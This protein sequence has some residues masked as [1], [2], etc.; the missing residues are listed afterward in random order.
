MEPLTIA[1]L[2]ALTPEDIEVEFFDDRMELIDYETSTD[3][4]AITVETYTA[5]RAYAIAAKYRER[6]IP[7]IMGGYHPTA[8]PEEVEMFAD[9]VM[10]GNT[11]TTWPQIIR[12]LREKTL[13]KRYYGRPG[14]AV[15][16]DRSIFAGKNYLPLGLVETGRGCPFQCEFCVISSYYQ[17]RYYPRPINDVVEDIKRSGRQ[18]FFLV[19]DNIIA[20]PQYAIQLC[21][22]LAQLNIIWASQASLN[23]AK[24]RELLRWLAKSGCRVLL[25]GFESCEEENLQQMNKAWIKRIGERDELVQRIHDAGISIYATF[26]FGFDHD[27]PAS[28]E[29]ALAFSEKHGFFFAAFNHLLP[30]PGSRLYERLRRENRLLAEKWW[31]EPGYEYGKIVFTPKN[32]APQ[33]LSDRCADARRR[34]FRFASIAKRGMQ[35][36]RRHPPLR[37]FA[38][39]WLQNF[40][41]RKEVDGRLGLPIGEGLDEL[42]K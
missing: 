7:V 22:E 3:A 8:I 39:Y 11:E 23:V 13:Q 10:I 25:I 15:V 2:K 33:E 32:M 16:P 6:G 40:N 12:D 30:F 38:A 26:V 18:Y 20:D 19:D 27:T 37:L 1:T 28:F 29:K 34:F 5:K 9:A 24:D 4:V 31:L 21:K 35:L 42:P 36:M 17:S 41:L 14:Y